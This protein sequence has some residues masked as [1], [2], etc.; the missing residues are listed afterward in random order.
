MLESRVT[1]WEK[2]GER[3][4]SLIPPMYYAFQNIPTFYVKKGIPIYKLAFLHLP[5]TDFLYYL[6]FRSRWTSVWG[7]NMPICGTSN[8]SNQF[9]HKSKPFLKYCR[10]QIFP[11]L[12]HRFLQEASHHA[13]QYKRLV[14]SAK[15]AILLAC[16]LLW[17]ILPR[18]WL[19]D[20]LGTLYTLTFMAE[21]SLALL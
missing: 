20:S 13:Q 19:L 7:Y 2:T 8:S 21:L 1:G 16:H 15:I 14:T 10:H 3:E 12:T 11:L 4:E 18:G 17:I 6:S 9:K 5:E